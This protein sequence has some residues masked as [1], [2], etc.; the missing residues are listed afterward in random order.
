MSFSSYFRRGTRAGSST[1]QSG[2]KFHC[3]DCDNTSTDLT[4]LICPKD[5]TW[6]MTGAQ[7]I[8]EAQTFYLVSNTGKF[9]FLQIA[10]SNLS[11]PAQ[12]TCQYAVRVYDSV[13][14]T[15]QHWQH[16]TAASKMK[17]S[18]DKRSVQVKEISY[19]HEDNIEGSFGIQLEFSSASEVSLSI[20]FK[21][22]S[23]PFS[24][25]DG[26][27]HFGYNK[28]DGFINLKF[29][30]FGKISGELTINDVKE[31][32][33]GYGLCVHQFQGLKPYLSAS[34]WNLVYFQGHLE[35]SSDEVS[36]FMLQMKTPE[37]Y[38]SVTFNIGSFFVN[39][40]LAGVSV[41]N[42]VENFNPVHDPESDYMIPKLINYKWKGTTFS[43][44]SF[45]LECEMVPDR[46]VHKVN[47][48]ANLP[49]FLRKAIEAFVTRPYAYYWLDRGELKMK[50]GDQ[51]SLVKG[52]I[53]Q[54]LSLINS[55]N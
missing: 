31:S 48:L 34:K 24:I 7:W 25:R 40:K 20:Q 1:N 12:T 18:P 46:P 13:T 38:D 11:W 52:W 45:D 54:E 36:A 47:V 26:S 21:P 33:S 5:F 28:S 9:L 49:Y 17:V 2:P 19:Q 37:N 32:Y 39:G 10:F 53:V 55:E 30:P 43:N 22:L 42:A 15:S 16:N 4:K 51:E 6:I 41:G 27:V 3:H 23:E 44:E 50:V 14:K 8:T 35:N 29:I